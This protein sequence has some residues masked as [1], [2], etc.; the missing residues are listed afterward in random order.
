MTFRMFPNLV[1][2]V[3]DPDVSQLGVS[4]VQMAVKMG[5]C[6]CSPYVADGFFSLDA[7]DVIVS[8][9]AG[10]KIPKVGK[11]CLFSCKANRT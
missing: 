1:P 7:R 11:A 10:T 8:R 4:T 6:G 2:E 9:P 5:F 3:G